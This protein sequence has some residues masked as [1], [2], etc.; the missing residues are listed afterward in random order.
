LRHLARSTEARG[1]ELRI[2]DHGPGIPEDRRDDVWR[3]FERVGGKTDRATDG[4]G[5]GLAVARGFVE[6]MDGE[7]SLEDTPGG[8]LTAVI[9]LPLAAP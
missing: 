1:V 3:P 9:S 6:L 2:A 8:G 7:L 4:V 5:L